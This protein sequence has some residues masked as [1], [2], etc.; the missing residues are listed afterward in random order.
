[1]TFVVRYN[2]DDMC[3]MRRLELQLLRGQTLIP[4]PRTVNRNR[5]AVAQ[6]VDT[7]SYVARHYERYVPKKWADTSLEMDYL[8]M[9]L[10]ILHKLSTTTL[11]R[12]LE[13]DESDC[14]FKK[15][16][17]DKFLQIMNSGR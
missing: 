4:A 15:S 6:F 16:I 2:S 17:L 14:I 3:I 13:Y 12:A 7:L 11:D 8:E 5:R 10:R 1:M 9:R